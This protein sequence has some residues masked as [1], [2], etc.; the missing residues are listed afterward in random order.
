MI[1]QGPHGDQTGPRV[2]GSSWNLLLCRALRVQ[3]LMWRRLMLP[4]PNQGKRLLRDGR[5]GQETSALESLIRVLAS[6]WKVRVISAPGDIR[7]PNKF[8][9]CFI[10]WKYSIYFIVGFGVFL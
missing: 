7:I 1:L 6:Y 10:V 3:G 5:L 9:P 2:D 4:S 8:C